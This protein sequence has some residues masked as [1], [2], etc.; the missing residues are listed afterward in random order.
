[1][2]GS[3]SGVETFASRRMLNVL[4]RHECVACGECCR[5]RGHVFLY[6]QDIKRIARARRQAVTAF[7]RESCSVVTC[8]SSARPH[9]RIALGRKANGECAF[10]NGSLCSI[11]RIKPLM[12][13]AGP[14]GWPWIGNPRFFWYYVRRSPSFKH[15]LGTWPRSRMNHWFRRTVRA[16]RVAQQA[17][18][19]EKLARMC[20]VPVACIRKLRITDFKERS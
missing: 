12:C 20:E 11:H 13:K 5:W 7:L 4:S 6:A 9:F 19:L 2:T 3:D 1:M 8:A 14:A 16:E 15:A 10:L 17:S 18:S